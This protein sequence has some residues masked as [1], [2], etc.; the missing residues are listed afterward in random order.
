MR[1]RCEPQQTVHP[2]HLT[3]WLRHAHTEA[4]DVSMH[5]LG[6]LKQQNPRNGGKGSTASARNQ[7]AILLILVRRSPL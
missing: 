1:H 6:V 4:Q 5:E 3:N 7:R 2:L